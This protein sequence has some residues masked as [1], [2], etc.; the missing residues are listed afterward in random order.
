MACQT[1]LNS[2]INPRPHKVYLLVGI[3][4]LGISI[5][6]YNV[7]RTLGANNIFDCLLLGKKRI[8]NARMCGVKIL[9]E[10]VN[11]CEVYGYTLTDEGSKE[12]DL[13]DKR[14]L[15]PQEVSHLIN[16]CFVVNE[17]H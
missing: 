1:L 6:A 12:F 2:I 4:N 11:L 13:Q 16:T 15:T 3:N 14:N 17:K 9:A 10:I 7:L 5:R 8:R